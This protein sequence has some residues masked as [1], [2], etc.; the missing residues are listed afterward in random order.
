M[1][2]RILCCFSF[3]N[4]VKLQLTIENL[5]GFFFSELPLTL[6]FYNVF[7]VT[8]TTMICVEG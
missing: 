8:S 3:S 7:S 2:S 6:M 4:D 1:F 5:I